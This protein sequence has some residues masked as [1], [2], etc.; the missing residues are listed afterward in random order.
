MNQVVQQPPSTRRVINAIK[1][2]VVEHLGEWSRVQRIQALSMIS[3][4]SFDTVDGLRSIRSKLLIK[5][6]M[7]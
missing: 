3:S 1:H 2:L 5:R 4:R 7:T 6:E